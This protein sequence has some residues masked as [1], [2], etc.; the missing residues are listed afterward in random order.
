MRKTCKD[1]CVVLLLAGAFGVAGC[2][3]TAS[4]TGKAAAPGATMAR[5]ALGHIDAASARDLVSAD[6]G[7]LLLDV[8]EP[9]ELTGELGAIEGIKHIPLG[10]LPGR[11]A[12]LE[13]WKDRTVI[14]VCR[15]GRR[16]QAAGDILLQAGFRDVRNLDGGMIAWRQTEGIAKP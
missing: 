14:T 4:G 13:G 5:A 3:V 1:W 7:V 11:V 9:A 15:S 12:E 2:N 16:S 6:P 8:R 10:E